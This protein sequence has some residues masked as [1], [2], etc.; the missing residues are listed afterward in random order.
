M[1]HFKCE[2]VAVV[3]KLAYAQFFVRLYVYDTG[4]SLTEVTRIFAQ[5]FVYV[6]VSMI[7]IN[8]FFKWA[9]FLYLDAKM[10][11][12]SSEGLLDNLKEGVLIVDE[13]DFS[14]QF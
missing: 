12:A 13:V 1:G 10:L 3:A 11:Q 6:A 4:E 7:G 8:F 2:L 9:G 14:I 5:S